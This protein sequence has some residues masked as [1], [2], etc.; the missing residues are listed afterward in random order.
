MHRGRTRRHSHTDSRLVCSS[1][2]KT[3]TFGGQRGQ[4]PQRAR[5]ARRVGGHGARRI[6]DIDARTRGR[7]ALLGLIG[8][9]TMLVQVEADLII[10]L[11]VAVLARDGDRLRVESLWTSL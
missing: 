3:K 5:D 7:I 6:D 1:S 11:A 8:Q 2:S 4:S 10:V 9:G